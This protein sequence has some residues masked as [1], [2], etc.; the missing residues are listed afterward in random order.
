MLNSRLINLLFST[1]SI[2]RWN[3]QIRPVDFVELDKQSHKMIIAWLLARIEE[4]E[5]GTEIDWVKL[6][7]FAISEFMYRAVVTD[8]K[9]PVFHFLLKHKKEE[10]GKYA[11]ET[12]FPLLD[13]K[14]QQ[15]FEDYLSTDSSLIERRIIDAAHYLASRWEFGIIYHFYPK[16]AGVEE[17]REKIE[18]EVEDHLDLTGVRRLELGIKSKNFL[19]ICAMLRFQKRW[20]KTPR[21]P[22]TSVLG[23]MFF[24]A[25]I[26]YFF[27]IEYGAC[28]RKIYNNFFT[29]LFHDL[30]EALTRDIIS[31]V[32][33]GVKGLDEI[34]K[35]YE[36][37]LIEEKL[38]PLLPPYL[39]DEMR[40]FIADEFSNRVMI[41]GK[42]KK[43][44]D[45]EEMIKTYNK[46]LFDP[47]DGSLIKVADHLGAYIE[48]VSSINNGI[49]PKNLINAKN[50]LLKKYKNRKIFG[51]DVYNIL[52][53]LEDM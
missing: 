1:A 12:L 44:K 14:L 26:T 9:P 33:Y 16:A 52:E 48:A 13:Q 42:V 31:P 11:K 5:N 18:S 40:Y 21:I 35:E 46:D 6:V 8:L 53:K 32:K 25:V 47:I 29:A 24:V 23:H 28:D 19:E 39:R 43:I 51:I 41:D 34:L 38:L 15:K 4:T 3:D 20:A 10:I 2:D 27:S 36:Q 22:Q 17:I 30:P 37:N 49:K 7:D 45:E 50:D